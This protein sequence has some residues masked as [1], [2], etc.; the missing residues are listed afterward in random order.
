MGIEPAFGLSP[1]VVRGVT[2]GWTSGE[3]EEYWQSI[4][5]SRQL[6]VF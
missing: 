5:G 4:S 3:Y 2:R 1:K 6:R